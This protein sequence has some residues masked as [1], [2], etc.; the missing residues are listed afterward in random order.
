MTDNKENIAQLD[1]FGSEAYGK[2]VARIPALHVDTDEWEFLLEQVRGAYQRFLRLYRSQFGGNTKEE[3]RVWVWTPLHG[4]RLAE[5]NELGEIHYA[6]QTLSIDSQPVNTQLLVDACR[7][8]AS[9]MANIEETVRESRDLYVLVHAGLAFR[10]NPLG[11][12]AL[13]ELLTEMVSYSG[14]N[15]IVITGHIG[16]A[17][18]PMVQNLVSTMELP[19]PDEETIRAVLAG[20]LG[21]VNPQYH[22]ARNM[23]P[24]LAGMMAGLSWRQLST[25][26]REVAVRINDEEEAIRYATQAKLQAVRQI[27][28][29]VRLEPPM[30]RP[31]P[32]VGLEGLMEIAELLRLALDNPEYGVPPSSGILLAGPG[33]TGKTEWVNHLSHLL[34]LFVLWDNYGDRMAS[35]VGESEEQSRRLYRMAWAAGRLIFAQDEVEKQ[36]PDIQGSRS[37]GGVGARLMAMDLEFQERVRREGRPIVF[38]AT[39]NLE[40]IDN[41]TSPKL[42]R[43]TWRWYIPH[44]SEAVIAEIYAGHLR[45]LF[46]TVDDWD[47]QALARKL[48]QAMSAAV[49]DLK[50]N[51]ITATTRAVG[52]DVVQSIEVARLLALRSQVKTPSQEQLLE[53]I[54]SMRQDMVA[55]DSE[56]KVLAR[57]AG[58]KPARK[59]NQRVDKGGLTT[60]N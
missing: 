19:Y 14:P 49:K 59:T 36:T 22:D 17:L 16:G 27:A 39:A 2:F 10:Q 52:R 7:T 45:R 30:E 35:H 46:G 26:A 55:L 53:A 11:A 60:L 25:V 37:D 47:T 41:L 9:T 40:T 31:H 13:E 6:A 24:A 58:E 57:W 50:G 23:P 20:T 44:P 38:V 3:P 54:A 12:V 32:S 28:P 29:F 33:G 34:G 42:S 51:D 4:L 8:I 15:R 56:G 5:W 1:E 18:P 48:T 21:E 43:Y